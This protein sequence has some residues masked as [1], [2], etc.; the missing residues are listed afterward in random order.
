MPA[1]PKVILPKRLIFVSTRMETGL[2]LVCTS[3]MEAIIW[4][5]I[6]RAQ[7][8]YPVKVCAVVVMCNHI[9]I[10]IAVE[11][12]SDVVGFMDR[13]KTETSHAINR[14]LG[15]RQRTV[16]CD[17]YDSS[18]VLTVNDAIEKFIY[19]YTNP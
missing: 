11:D 14:L 2:P 6:A 19:L 5:I 4:G 8:L 1:P 18:T 3:Y 10:L 12:P 16:W 9:H 15:R 13:V 7:V 17:G